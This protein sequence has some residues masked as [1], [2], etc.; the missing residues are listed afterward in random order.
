M[1]EIPEVVSQIQDWI[2]NDRTVCHHV[3]N[4]GMHGVME[5]HR[6]TKLRSIFESVDLFAPD[7]ILMVLLARIKG[8][9]IAKKKT[10]PDV[11]WEFART[12]SERGY[13]S[14]F[15]GDSEPVLQA[16]EARLKSEFP[17]LKIVGHRS[18]PFRK[19]TPE[20]DAADVEA[21]NRAAP[22]VLWVSL[23][24]PKQEQWISDHQAELR[25]P[26]AIG[27]GAAFKFASGYLGRGPSWLRNTGFEWMWRL[28]NEPRRIWRRVLVDAPQFIG[29][30]TLEISGLRKFR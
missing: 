8:F 6:D 18:P 3:V 19:L 2:E 10:G 29:L 7:G 22:D 5:A 12:A 20:E 15:Y 9:K 27:A 14:Y 25:V 1:V 16:M 30:V 21:I 23:G 17:N 11:I 24:M 28:I 13:S 4:S 26:V